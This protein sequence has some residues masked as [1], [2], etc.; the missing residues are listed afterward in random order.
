MK[1]K[2]KKSFYLLLMLTFLAGSICAQNVGIN[3]DGSPPDSSAMLDVKSTTKGMLIPRMTAAQIGAIANPADGLQAY[4]TDNGK[5]YVF[6][7]SAYVWKELSSGTDTT[8]ALCGNILFDSRDGKSYSTVL[9]GTQCWMA[10]NLNV[11]NVVNGTTEQSNNG[12][13]EKYCY[14][15]QITNCDVY[16]GLYQWNEM[17]DYT[18][19]SNTNPSGVQGICPNGW[20]V[21]SYAEWCQVATYLDYTVICT[22]WDCALTGTDTGGK[23]KE[24]GYT[25][26]YYPNEG[27][28][29]SS[30]LTI[31]P[32]GHRNSDG[33]FY[34]KQEETLL[35][36]TT[37]VDNSTNAYCIYLSNWEQLICF[38]FWET[39]MGSPVRCIKD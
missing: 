16:G 29:N 9:V 33:N 38:H 22:M 1:T 25:H 34:G 8:T 12:I 32:S 28:T 15:N 30:G 7:S 27:A 18:L 4:N 37:I 17:M 24:T 5:I 31:L 39:F 13:F 21:P 3:D 14:D 10:Q 2:M 11:G 19:S 20:H 35:W 36:S 6:V 26:W 23:M